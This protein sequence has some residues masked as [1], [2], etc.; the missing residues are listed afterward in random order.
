V[1]DVQTGHKWIN[2]GVQYIS[3]S[4]DVGIVYDACKKTVEAFHGKER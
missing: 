3:Y 2:L 1:D 4:V